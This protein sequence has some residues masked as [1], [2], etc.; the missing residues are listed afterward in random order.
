MNQFG[1]RLSAVTEQI[2]GE[3]RRADTGPDRAEDEPKL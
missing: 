3:K 2:P 1:P